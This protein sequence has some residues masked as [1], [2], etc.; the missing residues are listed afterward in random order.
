MSL[1]ATT[2][3]P[4]RRV[5]PRWAPAPRGSGRCAPRRRRRRQYPCEV[6]SH[7]QTSVIST[8][9]GK[10]A[11]RPDARCTI[12]SSS[13][14]P[15][16][17]SSFSF[18]ITERDHR[19]HAE[20]GRAPRLHPDVRRRCGGTCRGAPRPSD[21]GAT[22]RG[23]TNW[24]S[25]SRVSRT[26][27]RRG[28]CGGSGEAWCRIRAHD[29]RVRRRSIRR[30]ARAVPRVAAYIRPQARGRPPRPGHRRARGRARRAPRRTPSGAPRGE[31]RQR[32]EDPREAVISPPA[33]RPKITSSG[34]RRSVAPSPSGRRRAPPAAG[35]RGRGAPPKAPTAD[36]ARART[37][38]ADAPSHGPSTE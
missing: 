17:C 14:A 3:A 5:R 36:A 7:R 19:L 24:S 28:P 1:G 18:G 6:Y 15:V 29:R 37:T 35:C 33:S 9:S 32:D 34:W 8:S 10:R 11:R 20:P 27:P 21:S 12:P 26:R 16:A 31:Q 13:H 30:Q 38:P 4:A 23:I 2:S 22:K 25:E